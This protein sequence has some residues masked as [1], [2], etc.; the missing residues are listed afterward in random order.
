M[1]KKIINFF[2]KK[3]ENKIIDVKIFN[4]ILQNISSIEVFKFSQD[5]LEKISELDIFFKKIYKN[6]FEY[7]LNWEFI[8]EDELEIITEINKL[9]DDFNN[10]NVNL[11]FN[12]DFNLFIKKL[13]LLILDLKEINRFKLKNKYK[14]QKLPEINIS[15]FYNYS[16]NNFEL[17]ERE[18]FKNILLLNIISFYFEYFSDSIIELNKILIS[19]YEKNIINTSNTKLKEEREF[20]IIKNI[21]ELLLYKISI[22]N[23][24][25]KLNYLKEQK[26]EEINISQLINKW[27]FKDY[28]EILNFLCKS[29]KYSIDNIYKKFKW[30]EKLT[31]LEQ[32]LLIKYYKN[33][34]KS[35]DILQE[36]FSQKEDKN[37]LKLHEKIN[38][39]YIWNNLLSLLISN[40]KNISKK[41]NQKNI[42]EIDNLYA[43]ITLLHKEIHKDYKNH[44][45]YLK[46]AQFKNIQ[47]KFW[48]DLD[49]NRVLT[50]C[51]KALE[52][53]KKELNRLDYNCFYEF[54]FEDNLLEIEIPNKDSEKIY[55]HNIFYF[56]F[57]I[58]IQKEKIIIEQNNLFQNKTDLKFYDKFSNIE[59]KIDN[60]KLDA[61]AVIWLFTWIVVYSLW[62]IQIFAIIEDLW[63]A[64]MFAWVFLSWILFLLWWIYYNN[65]V[66]FYKNKW[67]HLFFIAILVLIF[68]F[69]WKFCFSWITLNLNKANN[70][71]QD[72]EIQIQKAEVL[73][74]L[75][76]EKIKK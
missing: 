14:R 60:N 54:D 7:I 43:K 6:L 73:N 16:D 76:E 3:N 48:N 13:D 62:T 64:I 26:I 9:K 66:K 63:S 42:E 52:K 44:F 33:I 22:I 31:N 15:N 57:D 39:I 75:L 18:N 56:P 45:S 59:E 71:K 1:F 69:I 68:T 25:S 46:Y 10:E 55:L 5:Y 17:K 29:S 19:I 47:Y 27:L 36:L 32:L 24:T 11:D 67:F 2:S 21:I 34:W 50:F 72:L 49:K 12:N 70:L 35:K 20:C 51:E 38:K 74:K 41:D 65:K 23:K 61:I 4:E 53:A 30:N 8:Y 28:K 58:A 40:F 37:E